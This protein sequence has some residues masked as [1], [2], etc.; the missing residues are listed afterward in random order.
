MTRPP[1]GATAR[2]NARTSGTRRDAAVTR[3]L[4]GIKHPRPGFL[5]ILDTKQLV[6]GDGTANGETD[7]LAQ[8]VG[9]ETVTGAQRDDIVGD[10]HVARLERSGRAEAAPARSP[11][12]LLDGQA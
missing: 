3:T 8:V 12:G 11:V 10:N 1:V 9:G 5:Q 6:A 7:E 4:I 2:L